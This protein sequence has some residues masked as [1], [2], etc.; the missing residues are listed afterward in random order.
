MTA[1]T[2][3]SIT[4]DDL[5]RPNPQQIQRLFEVL[6]SILM[7]IS[8]GTVSPAMRVAAEDQVV[9]GSIADAER[10]YSADTRDLMGF[11]VMLRKLMV[12]CTI[13]DFAFSDLYKPTHARL[14]KILSYVINFLRFRES[15]TRVM[16]A[17]FAES[18]RSKLRVQELYAE[19]EKL[20]IRLA[21]L[22]KQNA[23]VVVANERKDREMAELKPKL[24]ELD[25]KKL[26]LIADG[27]RNEEMK[28]HLIA[29]LTERATTL[30]TVSEEAAK[31]RPYTL[32]KPDALETNL[33]DIAAPLA[34]D[35]GTLED[36]ER[37]ARELTTSAE[38]F[39][40]S[41]ADVESAA[42]AMADLASDVQREE[43]E[44]RK[45]SRNR[46]LVS[47]RSATV[48][49]VNRQ[50]M[51]LQKQWEAA[52]QRTE[53]LRQ[54]HEEKARE[55]ATRMAALR[56]TQAALARDRQDKSREMDRRRIRIEQTEK[57][58]CTS[59]SSPR[60]PAY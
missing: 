5:R 37:R 47:D 51:I 29:I 3:I 25:R 49:D 54:M 16:D 58:V 10:L 23:N 43:A 30:D 1:V 2:G 59:H 17:H 9:S 6:A 15:Q 19:K 20:E 52:I 56:E 13:T 40:S 4:L 32:Q 42:R 45:A 39:A 38:V 31:L 36:L 60:I 55:S 53:K 27:K 14:Q 26:S 8:R 28:Q 7:N 35:R 12:Q 46:D 18:E 21:H 34:S 11:F 22:V 44:M 57:K 24:L 50:E 48:Q 41:K 33:R